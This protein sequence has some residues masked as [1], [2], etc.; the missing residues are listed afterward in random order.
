MNR[1]ATLSLAV[2]TLAA[3]H[4]TDIAGP[5]PDAVL[6]PSFNNTGSTAGA[7]TI[8]VMSRN[9]YI[10]ADVD[11]VIG[12]LASPDPSDDVPALLAAV[13]TLQNTSFPTRAQALADEIARARPHVLGMQEVDQLDIDLSAL[14]APIHISLDFLPTLQAALAARGLHYTL[15]GQVTNLTAN[16]VP[17][18]SVTD[19][20][21]ILV[22]ADRV[23]VG[24]TVTARTFAA[25]IG[26]VAP[27]VVLQRGWVAID[28]TIS[29]VTIRVAST[30]LESGDA[31]GL[32][33]LRA[34]QALELV[35]SVGAASPAILLGDFN[36]GPGSSMHDVVTGA[37]FTDT[38]AALRPGVR[39]VTC[40]EAPD[41]SNHVAQLDQRIDYVFARG[42]GGPNGNVLGQVTIVGDQP[43][44]RVAG[45]S[46]PIWPSDH[47][48]LVATFLV[49]PA[50]VQVAARN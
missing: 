11:A 26:P 1:F 7:R 42:I 45:P 2:V 13:T 28:A 21:V 32:A 5:A 31:P 20:D 40:C 36:D 14:G 27:G 18:I 49:P 3:C 8:T 33:G 23:T 30:H 39:G 34:V 10:G 38:W 29:G 9:L 16:P 6:R 37:G 12:A 41:L 35:G 22:D 44:E 46:F 24:P 25:N 48:G 15:A 50:A 19:H 43:G 4:D 47:A 17:G